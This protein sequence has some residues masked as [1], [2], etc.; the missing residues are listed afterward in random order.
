MRSHSASIDM[1]EGVIWKHI[2]SFG[3]P[4][5]FGMLFQQMYNAVDAV[6]VGRF[7]G[8]G[9]LAAV[10]STGM[11]IN[12][13]VCLGTGLSGGAGIAIAQYYGAHNHKKLSTAVHTAITMLI[14]LSV[15]LTAVGFIIAPPMLRLMK[16]PDDVMPEAVTYLRI[17]FLGVVGLILYNIGAGILRAVGDSRRPLY[18]LCISA[19]VNTVGDLIFVIA[20][21]MG[22]AGVALATILAQ[23]ISAV[24]VLRVLMRTTEPYG[25]RLKLL[26]IDKTMLRTIVSFGLP[27]ALQMAVTSFS[28]VFVQSYINLFGSACMAGWTAY[29]K[30][31]A[32]IL[33]PI[34]GI[35]IALATFVGQNYG[36]GK[37]KRARDSV[38]FSI[39]ASFGITLLLVILV[40]V[41]QRALLGIFS[42][43]EESM[44][45]GMR[46]ISIITPFYLTTCFDSMYS[47]ALRGIG[48]TKIP[49]ICTLSAYVVFRQIYLFVNRTWLGG[50]FVGTA[51]GYPFGWLLGCLLLAC[52]Y[53]RCELFRKAE[54][55]AL[56]PSSET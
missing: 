31:D 47:N 38:R 53:Y 41:F 52:F 43:E 9:A 30:I 35:N 32:F 3:V 55:S 10:G 12:T 17:Y 33:L 25:L 23:G 4:I 50:T 7:V 36:A 28:N 8:D 14:F 42:L 26:G 24:L 15:I 49:M 16:T 22:V 40:L 5:M 34:Q 21:D 48:Q 37:Y 13:M 1:T 20:F 39:A 11:I 46:F 51:L 27:G 45:Y 44:R 19:A 54:Q 2:I 6:I 29:N 18:F 56:P